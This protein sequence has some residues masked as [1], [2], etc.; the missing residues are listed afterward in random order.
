MVIIHYFFQGRRAQWS[1]RDELIN[2]AP[3]FCRL[4]LSAFRLLVRVVIAIALGRLTLCNAALD[5]LLDI[6][7]RR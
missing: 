5:A 1:P 7:E 6:G 4:V 2:R 3:Q